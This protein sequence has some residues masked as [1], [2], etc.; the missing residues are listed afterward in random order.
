ML[1]KC[2]DKSVVTDHILYDVG[3]AGPQEEIFQNSQW[4]LF[5]DESLEVFGGKTSSSNGRKE[6]L[7][8]SKVQSLGP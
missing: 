6:L 2:C 5:V 8:N 7:T 1:I 3:S 4:P